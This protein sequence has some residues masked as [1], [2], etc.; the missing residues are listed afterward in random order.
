MAKG[1]IATVKERKWSTGANVDF[2]LNLGS[3]RRWHKLPFVSKRVFI[4]LSETQVAA[5]GKLKRKWGEE[6]GTCGFTV[7]HP[8]KLVTWYNFFPT[9][10]KDQTRLPQQGIGTRVHQGIAQFI[11]EHYA[12]YKVTHTEDV[13]MDNSRKMQLSK[14]GIN[15]DQPTHVQEYLQLVRAYVEKRKREGKW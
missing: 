8:K 15:P 1:I 3:P 13:F 5:L 6:L 10:S 12:D 2:T 4:P 11:A 9:G 7:N 14:M